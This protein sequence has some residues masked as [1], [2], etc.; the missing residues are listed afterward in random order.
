ML[1]WLGK[2]NL[3][4]FFACDGEEVKRLAMGYRIYAEKP[5]CHVL[6]DDRAIRFVGS[7]SW[8]QAQI[9]ELKPDGRSWADRE[10]QIK[11]CPQCQR[12][13]LVDTDEG[14]RIC[15]LCNYHESPPGEQDG[16]KTTIEGSSDVPGRQKPP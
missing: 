6:I 15:M 9:E 4:E 5:I 11:V 16:P 12:G 7:W 10:S 3:T 2:H 13:V 1:A 8:I 14:Y